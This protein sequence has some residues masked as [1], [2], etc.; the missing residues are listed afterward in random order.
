MV[1]SRVVEPYLRGWAALHMH[2][3]VFR[4]SAGSTW[5]DCDLFIQQLPF[6]FLPSSSFIL[7]DSKVC[8]KYLIMGSSAQ[9][10]GKVL[11]A[12]DAG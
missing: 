1:S 9:A 7:Q 4:Q 12:L 2:T 5:G 3:H 10:T 8:Y 6:A 11:Y